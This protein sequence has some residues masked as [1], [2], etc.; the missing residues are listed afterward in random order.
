METIQKSCLV[1]TVIGAIN[2]GLIGILNLNLVTLLFSD[3][4][5]TNIIYV[6][7][8]VSGIVNIGV[9]FSHIRTE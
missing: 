9:L 5:L 2:W 1:L 3:S 4:L 7:I 6:L 8:G